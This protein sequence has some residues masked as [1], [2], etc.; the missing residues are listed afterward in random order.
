M[1]DVCN[2]EWKLT[3][4]D[5]TL[6]SMEFSPHGFSS[7]SYPRKITP[8]TIH[9]ERQEFKKEWQWM[10]SCELLM[11]C[12]TRQ[13][14][15]TF[16]WHLQYHQQFFNRL[17][18]KTVGRTCSPSNTARFILWSAWCCCDTSSHFGLGRCT[19][20]WKLFRFGCCRSLAPRVENPS[21]AFLVTLLFSIQ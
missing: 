7:S 19:C 18:S 8:C 21:G 6:H 17:R 12:L 1:F 13:F 11:L 16:C 4:Y 10:Q 5:D 3:G 14:L 20:Q 2:R 9:G 15:L